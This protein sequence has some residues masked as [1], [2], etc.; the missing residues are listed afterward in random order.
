MAD[1]KEELAAEV[2]L[3][4]IQGSLSVDAERQRILGGQSLKIILD[5]TRSTVQKISRDMETQARAT[6]LM[7]ESMNR[8]AGTMLEILGE[9]KAVRKQNDELLSLLNYK[10]TVGSTP[11]SGVVAAVGTSRSTPSKTQFF[12]CGEPI[13][14]KYDTVA[15]FLSRLI[16]LVRE[17]EGPTGSGALPANAVFSA[18]YDSL[19]RAIPEFARTRVERGPAALRGGSVTIPEMASKSVVGVMR[20]LADSGP[21][22]QTLLRAE[23]LHEVCQNPS[24][25]EFIKACLVI[26]ARFTLVRGVICPNT[27]ALLQAVGDYPMFDTTPD[28]RLRVDTQVMTNVKPATLLDTHIRELKP[29]MRDEFI[30]DCCIE[31]SGSAL[32]R[33]R[34]GHYDSKPT[35]K[36]KGKG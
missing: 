30:R 17:A 11:G 21:A 2:R 8:M 7:A 12:M 10:T 4:A 16:T 28:V 31:G 20:M 23:D 36:A 26:A 29:K 25:A 1:Y 9:Y 5:N 15:C 33:L 27:V 22:S 14:N 13:H 19:R 6:Q 32:A 24:Y 35:A 18:D 3:A 34:N